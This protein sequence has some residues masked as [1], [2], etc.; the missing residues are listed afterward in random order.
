MKYPTTFEVQGHRGARGLLAENTLPSFEIA[1]DL[2]VTS[3]ETDVH[4]TRDGVAILFHDAEISARLCTP[5]PATP[6]L[7]SSLTLA[8]LRGYRIGPP[9]QSM[10]PLARCFADERGFEPFGIPTLTELFE[11]VQAYAGPQGRRL[12][13]TMI[14]QERAARLCFDLELKR[15]PFRPQ[16]VG[17]DFDGVTPSVLERQVIAAIRQAGVLGRTRVRSFDH[18][19]MVAIRRLEPELGAGLLIHHTAPV[20]AGQMLEL[21]GANWYCPDYHF[22]DAGIVRQVHESARQI[23]PYTVNEPQDWQRLI[24]WGVDGVTTDYPDRLINWLSTV[25]IEVA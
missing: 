15:V 19:S 23:I 6:L 25:G 17:D 11:F 5:S 8:E 20:H 3:I 12:G 9:G 10:T 22:V 14:Q 16:T 2:G 1:L 21:A 4:L 7:V 24:D 18:R 13:K